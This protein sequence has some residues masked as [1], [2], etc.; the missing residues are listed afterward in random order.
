VHLILQ[1]METSLRLLLEQLLSVLSQLWGQTLLEILCMIILW[2]MATIIYHLIMVLTILSLLFTQQANRTIIKRAAYYTSN[3][4]DPNIKTFNRVNYEAGFDI[5]FLHN[6][7]GLS[8][9][10]FEY[11]SLQ[12]D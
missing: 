4:Y 1:F 7:L 2:I 12:P 5:N 3:L 11:S 8:A 6:R 10:A 9:T